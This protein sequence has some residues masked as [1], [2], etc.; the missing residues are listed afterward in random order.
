MVNTPTT[1]KVLTSAIVKP[2]PKWRLKP[3][4]KVVEC[5]YE[6]MTKMDTKNQ[7]CIG[8]PHLLS[9]M[10]IIG[11]QKLWLDMKSSYPNDEPSTKRLHLSSRV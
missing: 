6:A 4:T 7:T 1:S 8:D 3:T 2:W 5:H 9:S 10:V 11:S